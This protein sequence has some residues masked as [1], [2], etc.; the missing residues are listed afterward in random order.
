M[1]AMI[2]KAIDKL[3]RGGG[4]KAKKTLKLFAKADMDMKYSNL[5]AWKILEA[6]L[7]QI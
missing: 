4:A 5:D 6:A 2:W 1:G 3:N 7:I